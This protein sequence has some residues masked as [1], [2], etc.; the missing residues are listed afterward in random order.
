[1][2]P[3]VSLDGEMNVPGGIIVVLRAHRVF[4]FVGR[5]DLSVA[6]SLSHIWLMLKHAPPGL[7]NTCVI[8]SA[9]YE[10][11]FFV[12]IFSSRTEAPSASQKVSKRICRSCF[13]VLVA[14]SRSYGS[15]V[16][17]GNAAA[18]VRTRSHEYV[19]HVPR[20]APPDSSKGLQM[21]PLF[22]SQLVLYYGQ[23][24]RFNEEGGEIPPG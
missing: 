20:Y 3:Y 23:T 22:R 19:T 10:F 2:K 5:L 12:W 4:V 1:M 11:V 9:H 14:N 8:F 17:S 16:L 7:Q 15:G 13:G 18:W 24:R 21:Q 6:R